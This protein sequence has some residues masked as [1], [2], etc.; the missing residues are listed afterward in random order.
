MRINLPWQKHEPASKEPTD[1]QNDPKPTEQ[2][3]DSDT[4]RHCVG[5]GKPLSSKS[6]YDECEACRQKKASMAQH[7]FAAVGAVGAA[8]FFGAR[9]M[10]RDK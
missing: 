4:V 7:F 9:V 3:S 10:K 5:C 2:K 1:E 6:K 8:I